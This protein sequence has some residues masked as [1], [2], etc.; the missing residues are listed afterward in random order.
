MEAR[1]VADHGE[2]AHL[3][4]PQSLRAAALARPALLATR[5]IDRQPGEEV[6]AAAMIEVQVRVDD[7][8]DA[9]EIEILLAQRDQAGSMSASRGFPDRSRRERTKARAGDPFCFRRPYARA[10]DAQLIRGTLLVIDCE[11]V[12]GVR[13]L[14]PLI[15]VEPRGTA[16]RPR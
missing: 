9:G 7:E 5:H 12:L 10:G 8:V 1:A 6:V 14:A 2:A 15:L 16:P 11:Q 3:Q 4:W 13:M